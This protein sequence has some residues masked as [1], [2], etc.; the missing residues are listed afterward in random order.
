MM[1]RSQVAD[2]TRESQRLRAEI[3][4]RERRIQELEKDLAD[5]RSADLAR[6][7]QQRQQLELDLQAEREAIRRANER[8]KEL[9]AGRATQPPAKK[10]PEGR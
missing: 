8:L 4:S 5:A 7:E 10:P 3:A 1:L 6:L 9:E 2:M